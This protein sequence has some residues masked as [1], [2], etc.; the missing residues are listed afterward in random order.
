MVLAELVDLAQEA[1]LVVFDGWDGVSQGVFEHDARGQDLENV[2]NALAEALPLGGCELKQSSLT[3]RERAAFMCDQTHG[4]EAIE[5]MLSR[6]H[7]TGVGSIRKGAPKLELG[8][9]G[10]S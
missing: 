5:D 1:I 3:L 8:I 9:C 4:V 2:A 7:N 10:G 6:A